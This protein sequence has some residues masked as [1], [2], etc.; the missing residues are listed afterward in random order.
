MDATNK[1]ARQQA[2]TAYWA[3]GVLHSC[4]GSYLDNYSGLIGDF[5]RQCF[6]RLKPGASVLDLA[7]GNG[8]LPLMLWQYVD[9][10]WTF[11]ID[12]IDLASI[13]PTWYVPEKYP[14]ITLHSGVSMESL[15]FE[16]G[17]DLI[18]SQY[19]LEYADW[20]MALNEIL[21][22]RRE[23]GEL[24]FVM[25]HAD[26]VLVRVG[27]VEMKHLQRL[28]AEDGLLSA[29]AAVLPWLSKAREGVMP[30]SAKLS[31][32]EARARYNAE[33]RRLGEQLDASPAPDLMHQVMQRVHGILAGNESSQVLLQQL[34]DLRGAMHSA[35]LRIAEMV[36]CALTHDGIEQRAADLRQHVPDCRVE[37]RPLRQAEGLL[38][39][40]L[41]VVRT[42]DDI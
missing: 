5:W 11:R 37:Y 36:E 32:N 27:R 15:P 34:N 26:S 14:E 17:F 8:A 7:S 3:T 29:A 25:H 12:A 41:V 18:I 31:A 22:V 35:L 6:S 20:P 33:M 10:R 9:G 1:Q 2:W 24:A 16:S 30:A 4:A 23:G 21:R 38:G 42:H 39:W 28:L 13:T 40:A 19:G